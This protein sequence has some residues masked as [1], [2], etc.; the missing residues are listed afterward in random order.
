VLKT[1]VFTRQTAEVGLAPEVSGAG[2]PPKATNP[3]F[4]VFGFLFSKTYY[5]LLR[6]YFCGLCV[7]PPA[8][9]EVEGSEVTRFFPRA[10]VWRVGSRSRGIS[11][12]LTVEN[13]EFLS[14]SRVLSSEN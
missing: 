5:F 10:A 8:L 13:H 3:L 4:P 12:R 7:I 1:Q 6:T 2:P 11:L 14:P 9:S